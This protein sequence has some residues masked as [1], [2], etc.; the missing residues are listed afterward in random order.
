VAFWSN[1]NAFP[2]QF[3]YESLDTSGGQALFT[4]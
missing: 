3:V 4:R 1:A 2:S